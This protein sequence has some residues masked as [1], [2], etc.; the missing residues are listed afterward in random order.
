MTPLG[1]RGT[2]LIVV[3]PS[4]AGKTSLVRDLVQ[5]TEGLRVSV[6]YTTRAARHGEQN[7]VDYCFISREDFVARRERGE[8]LE[9]AEVHGNFY[10]TS[11]AW[12]E[13]Q[14]NSG[15]DI[16]LE[17]DWQGATQVRR[18]IPEAITVFIAPPSMQTLRQRLKERGSDTP[19][20]IERRL[21]AAQ[22][23]LEHAADCQ[24]VIINQDFAKAARSLAAILDAARCRFMTQAS[25]HSG[26]F[27]ELGMLR[28][29]PLINRP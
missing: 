7:G 10:G 15:V 20:V 2:L 9:W 4:G 29:A 21:A 17:I 26:L 8:F 19:E 1:F 28:H 23:E 18:L 3:A 22:S 14:M 12:L 5:R 25:S 11:R 27:T 6:S 24:Y 16:V 13:A